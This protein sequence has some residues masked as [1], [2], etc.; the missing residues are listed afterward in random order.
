MEPSPG[1]LD[2][3]PAQPDERR[4]I[5]AVVRSHG[6][7]IVALAAATIVIELGVYAVAVAAS[8]PP[9]HACL[10]TL[11]VA[12][13]WTAIAA[14]SAAAGAQDALGA[15]LRAGIVADASA[16]A[17]VVLA[18]A[19]PAVSASSAVKAW[20]ILAGMSMLSASLVCLA[21]SRAAKAA[22]AAV[23][24]LLL[25][26]SL[27]SP[28]WIGGAARSADRD[29]ARSALAL[30]VH[31]NPFY[32]IT[33]SLSVQ[34]GFVWHRDGGL[35]YANVEGGYYGAAPPARWYAPVLIDLSAALVLGIAAGLFRRRRKEKRDYGD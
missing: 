13:L 12:V 35:M 16:V 17:L 21:R 22:L 19:S 18:L 9:L 23:V 7:A 29:F 10:A 20:C 5:A 8:T 26:A 14:P 28:F 11:A 32:G 3:A 6:E 25:L 15:F 34:P 24:G 30:A 2:L 33:G 31:V 1:N 27:A 4:S